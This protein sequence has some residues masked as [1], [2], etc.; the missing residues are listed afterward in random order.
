VLLKTQGTSYLYALM[1]CCTQISTANTCVIPM[2]LLVVARL[3]SSRESNT[4]FT[5]VQI[6]FCLLV[7]RGQP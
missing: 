3:R 7:K 1:I 6:G 5:T 2:T 4:E